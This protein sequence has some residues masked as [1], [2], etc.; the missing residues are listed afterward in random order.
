M[1]DSDDEAILL[2][3]HF[4]R[5]GMSDLSPTE[6]VR[7]LSNEDVIVR[8]SAAFLL[9]LS[10]GDQAVFLA[11][12]ALADSDKAYCREV[13]A[14]VLG[15]FGTPDRPFRSESLPVLGHLLEDTDVDVRLAA[16][17]ALR[18][19]GG[20]EARDAVLSVET[21]TSAEV[22]RLVAYQLDL[23]EQSPET[24]AALERLARDTDPDVRQ[25]AL[26]SLAYLRGLGA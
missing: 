25:E 20:P 7:F 8:S 15:Q 22:R 16:I 6:L 23:L 11:V 12:L 24:V 18:H 3:R 14:Y 2:S 21:D 17:S 10:G 5:K 1:L 4:V 13:A 9:H 26:E 19:L